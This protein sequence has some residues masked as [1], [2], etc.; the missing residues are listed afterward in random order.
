MRWTEDVI[1]EAEAALVVAFQPCFVMN[2]YDLG[3]VLD[4]QV[5]GNWRVAGIFDLMES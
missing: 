5:N 2:D 3:N 1:G 4:G